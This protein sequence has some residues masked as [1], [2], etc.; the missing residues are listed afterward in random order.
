MDFDPTNEQWRDI[1]GYGGK[2]QVSSNGRIGRLGG[3]GPVKNTLYIMAPYIDEQGR[4]KV[5]LRLQSTA[6]QIIVS[7]LVALAFIGPR[8]EG[9]DVLH[10]N[11]INSDNFVGNLRYGTKLENMADKRV[12]GTQPEGASS[13]FAKLT[14]EQVHDIRASLERGESPKSISLRMPITERS[15]SDV[16]LRKSW[17]HI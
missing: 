5:N 10:N 11:G 6:K 15:I 7:K 17:S 12:H 3:R 9:K 13:H 14:E 1:P 4:P 16:K 2:Y 8:P